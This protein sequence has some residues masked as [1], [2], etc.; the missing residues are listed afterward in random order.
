MLQILKNLVKTFSNNRNF[1]VSQS[2]SLDQYFVEYFILQN[3]IIFFK[4]QVEEDQQAALKIMQ[5]L[6]LRAKDP[7]GSKSTSSKVTGSQLRDHLN[8][9][10]LRI[11]AVSEALRLAEAELIN[12]K[13]LITRQITN[14]FNNS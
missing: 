5:E 7:D 11:S 14:K 3:K 4:N 8:K 13:S 9:C 1:K 2:P 12:K 6:S 10:N